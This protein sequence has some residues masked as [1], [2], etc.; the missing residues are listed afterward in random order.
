MFDLEAQREGITVVRPRWNDQE[1]PRDKG[2]GLE[3]RIVVQTSHMNEKGLVRTP[4]EPLRHRVK[5]V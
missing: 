3:A 4:I 1:D 5:G 2:R